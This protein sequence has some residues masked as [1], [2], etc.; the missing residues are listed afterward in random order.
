MLEALQRDLQEAL[1]D[2]ALERQVRFPVRLRC[3]PWRSRCAAGGERRRDHR[4]DARWR[5][6]PCA[7]KIPRIRSDERASRLASAH[8]DQGIKMTFARQMLALSVA[9]AVGCGGSAPG[10]TSVTHPPDAE[11]APGT[12]TPAGPRGREGIMHLS[13]TARSQFG[14][15]TAPTARDPGGGESDHRPQPRRRDLGRRDLDRRDRWRWSLR[16]RCA[17]RCRRTRSSCASPTPTAP[18][19]CEPSRWPPTGSMVL[20]AT[21]AQSGR[22]RLREQRLRVGVGADLALTEVPRQTPGQ[23]PRVQ[24]NHGELHCLP[25]TC[26]TR[27]ATSSFQQRL[28][29]SMSRMTRPLDSGGMGSRCACAFPKTPGTS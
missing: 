20:N 10:G 11:N 2:V 27:R 18:Q 6:S 21:L 4:K 17:G 28:L 1:E 25:I 3:A 23:G 8:P 5:Q 24:P 14:V 12:D 13:G 22:T 29:C 9:I 19:S 7:G 26:R 16:A 15:R